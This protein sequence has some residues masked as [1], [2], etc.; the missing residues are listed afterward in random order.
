MM[1]IVALYRLTGTG[2]EYELLHVRISYLV[3]SVHSQVVEIVHEI[4]DRNI[5][6][7]GTWR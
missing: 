7:S 6:R 1:Y 4:T 2:A 5:I 3:L